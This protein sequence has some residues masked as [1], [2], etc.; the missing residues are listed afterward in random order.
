MLS[1]ILSQ[2][3]FQVTCRYGKGFNWSNT[4]NTMIF[5][6][7]RLYSVFLSLSLSVLLSVFDLIDFAG[8]SMC[9]SCPSMHSHSH[10]TTLTTTVEVKVKIEIV[11]PHT[12]THIHIQDDTPHSIIYVLWLE[13]FLDNI[14]LPKFSAFVSIYFFR[15]LLVY[16][17][18]GCLLH[19]FCEQ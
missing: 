13:T 18:S 4:I 12:Y 3:W 10:W 19:R 11:F 15:S 9:A 7:C 1:L 5:L 14:F 2:I 17:L 16:P 6:F 8:F